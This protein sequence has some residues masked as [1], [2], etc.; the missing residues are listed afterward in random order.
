MPLLF[1]A[2]FAC[3]AESTP[4]FIIV[5]E[6]W[7]GFVALDVDERRQPCI[8][9]P[10]LQEWGMLR[11][12]LASLTFSAS[13]CVLPEALA[14]HQIRLWYVS[15]AQ[16][17]TLQIPQDILNHVTNG[18]ATSRWDDG[19]NAAFLDYDIGYTHYTGVN[20]GLRQHSLEVATTW[21]LNLGAWRFRYQPVWSKDIY[22]DP[23]WRTEKANA[24]RTLRSLRALLTLGDGTTPD[25]VFD[26]IDYRGVSLIADDRMLPDELRR[27]SPWIRGFARTEA[28][29]K[30]RQYG[31]LI[32]QITVPA[33]AFILKDIYPVD[34]SADLELMIKEE[35]GTETVRTI[36]Y[37]AMPNLVRE[38]QWK[39]AVTFG[40][41]RPY[42]LL[43]EQQPL[44]S[45]TMLSYGLPGDITLYGGAMLSSLYHSGAIGTGK[46]FAQWGAVSMDIAFSQA[47]DPRRQQADRGT[48][49]RWRYIKAFSD[50]QSAFSLTAAWYPKQRYRSFSEAVSQQTRY[51]WDWEGDRFIG[52]FG[53]EKKHS[54]AFSYSQNFSEEDNLYL[55]LTSETLRGK[56]KRDR[57]L[58]AGYSGSYGAVDYALGFSWQQ[59]QGERE[60]ALF[61]LSLTLPLKSLGLPHA[62]LNLE[63][64][65]PASSRTA[66]VSGTLLEDYSL[67]YSLSNTQEK[68]VNSTQKM[69]LNYQYNAG[70]A[71]GI[72]NRKKHG[73]SKYLGLTGSAVLHQDGI[74]L[75]QTLGETV[76][77]L[78]VPET[79]GIGIINQYGTTTDAR[80]FAVIGNLTP[81]RVNELML[82]GFSLEDERSLPDAEA[83]V[84]PT[85]GAIMYSRF[86]APVAAVE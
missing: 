37:T 15:E 75:G 22:S 35:D 72:Y 64:G 81:Y 27:L 70:N 24:F 68:G 34:S 83:E 55:T 84:V 9:A 65:L 57:L 25:S 77:L 4:V 40:N 60:Q 54:L 12:V 59:W 82:D 6:S 19:I 7:R 76:A 39:Y 71:L 58:E 38:G 78:E 86:K 61:T 26:S 14:R 28:E 48:Q 42:Y 74:T 11:G 46:R 67:S 13:G 52:E 31:T 85:A 10:L 50:W 41:Y 45:Q 36:P 44:F 33:G 30:I 2:A 49:A 53:A 51:G 56:K 73:G 5:N 20:Y 43:D 32:Y 62:R 23:R 63:S 17:L 69:S 66:G 79:G 8:T 1:A 18:V 80:G 16:V 29:V 21:G 47:A 3:A